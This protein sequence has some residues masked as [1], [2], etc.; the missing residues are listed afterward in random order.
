[1]AGSASRP[2]FYAGKNT[3]YVWLEGK[4]VSLGIRGKEAKADAMKEWHKLMANGKPKPKAEAPSVAEMVKAF[5]VDCE[6]RVKAITLRN[7]RDLLTPFSERFGKVKADRLTTQQAEAFSRKPEWSN[8]TRHDLLTT[9][10]TA[11]RWAE[12]TGLLASNPLRHLRKP[13]KESRGDR[14]L[15]SDDAHAKLYEA[16]PSYF[17][18]LLRLLFLTGC[19]PGEAAAITVENFDESNG[20]VRLREHKTARHGKSRIIFLCAE[21][22]ALLLGQKAKHGDGFLLRNR[23]GLAYSKDAIVQMMASLRRKTGVQGTAYGYR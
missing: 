4:K 8:S 6:G 21:A 12:R 22:V 13:P 15:V 23:Y 7:Y 20:V 10:A 3:W 9:V 14:A 18:P 11:F 1:M 16:A 17:K 2:W 5:L 19:R